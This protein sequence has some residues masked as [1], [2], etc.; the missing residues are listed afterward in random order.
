MPS[1]VW[2]E[3]AQALLAAVTSPLGVVALSYCLLN[4][5]AWLFFRKSGLPVRVFAFLMLLLFGVFVVSVVA[6]FLSP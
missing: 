2:R 6:T 4:G 5:M 1:V 3:V